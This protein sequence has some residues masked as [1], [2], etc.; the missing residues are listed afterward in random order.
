MSFAFGEVV[1]RLTLQPASLYS[2]LH[3]QPV[4]YSWK[5]QVEFW[6][7]HNRE[8]AEHP[9]FNPALGWDTTDP[10]HYRPNLPS[11]PFSQ[12]IVTIGDSFTHGDDV[13]PSE[14][15]PYLL[16]EL[17]EDARVLNMGVSGYAI[18]QAYLKY[19]KYGEK[20]QPEAV[21]FGIYVGD[22]GRTALSFTR[23]A[24][25]RYV[26]GPFGMTLTNQP[27][28]T[29]SEI[30]ATT[31]GEFSGRSYMFELVANT[32]RKI[33][34][35]LSTNAYYQ[36][37]DEIIEYIF[38]SL[39]DRLGDRRLIIVH[40]PKAEA[41]VDGNDDRHGEM[42]RRLLA[43]YDKLDIQVLNL[44]VYFAALADADKVFDDFYIHFE[45]GSVRHLS[46]LGNLRV[47]Q[48]L[49]EMLASKN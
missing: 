21:I 16:D 13:A 33:T 46:P 35:G 26:A 19:V 9:W 37:T 39:I 47:A 30:M 12:T 27:V 7:R 5:N 14:N 18:D 41:F 49:A 34:G 40:I 38:E 4:W 23:F 25:P 44:R 45:D 28:P 48:R 1:L 31:E 11:G 24:K 2:S 32:G 29:P 42:S 10:L 15:F 6:Q 43:I 8:V 36:A 17:L 22:Y 3:T 20:Y